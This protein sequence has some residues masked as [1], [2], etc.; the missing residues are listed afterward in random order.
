MSKRTIPEEG[1]HSPP[2][3][4]GDSILPVSVVSCLHNHMDLHI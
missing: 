1:Y 2:L 3:V 4:N